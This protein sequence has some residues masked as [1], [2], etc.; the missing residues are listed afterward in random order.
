MGTRSTQMSVLIWRQWTYLYRNTP[1][2]FGKIG[3][4]IFMCLFLGSIFWHP[5]DT[6]QGQ[7]TKLSAYTILVMF[8]SL[9]TASWIPSL[10]E[11][12]FVH[13]FQ[14]SSHYY[15]IIYFVL[16]MTVI[17]LFWIA[18]ESLLWVT[19]FSLFVDLVGDPFISE[20]FW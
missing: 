5:E 12:I 17:D 2:T 15:E 18:I 16:A 13:N 9:L 20:E 1:A 3:L 8:P 14:A 6:A 4:T 19:G 11:Q 10:T 7:E